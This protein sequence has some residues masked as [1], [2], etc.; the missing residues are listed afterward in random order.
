MERATQS[1]K[2]AAAGPWLDDPGCSPKV[3]ASAAAEVN[4]RAPAF[5]G[6]P[7]VLQI[8]Q[9][10][11][12]SGEPELRILLAKQL[13]RLLQA[14]ITPHLVLECF[15]RELGTEKAAEAS[16]QQ[17]PTHD[18]ELLVA[19]TLQSDPAADAYQDNH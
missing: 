9:S 17:G 14:H 18:A 5:L 6:P 11:R 16:A 4:M 12:D 3:D 1:I 8:I 15:Q 10:H 13:R 19:K 7:D 2:R